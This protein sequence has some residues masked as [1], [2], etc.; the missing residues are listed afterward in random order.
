MT[1]DDNLLNNFSSSLLDVEAAKAA[2]KEYATAA[3]NSKKH[4]VVSHTYNPETR[5]FISIETME[6]PNVMDHHVGE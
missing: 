5:E 2:F 3:K 6:G 4:T 1:T